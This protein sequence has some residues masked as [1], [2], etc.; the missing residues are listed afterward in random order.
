MGSCSLT[1]VECD[2][3][4]DCVQDTCVGAQPFLHCDHGTQVAGVLGAKGDSGRAIA[5]VSWYTRIMPV[6][7][8]YPGTLSPGFIADL[9]QGI[10]Y[11][12]CHLVD[13]MNISSA[14]FQPDCPPPCSQALRDAIDDARK[15]DI[16]VVV[17]AGNRGDNI[18][19]DPNSW[20]YPCQYTLNNIICV[21]SSDRSDQWGTD[22][23]GAISVDLAAP[24][25]E[26]MTLKALDPN[27]AAPV[28]GSSFAAPHVSGV[29]ALMRALS[30]DIPVKLIRDR[31]LDP[32]SLDLL[33]VF[34]PDP[35]VGTHPVATG[36]RLNAHKCLVDHDSVS[37]D[38][39]S[40]LTASGVVCTN[41]INL[42]WTATADDGSTGDPATFNQVRVSQ[43]SIADP[44]AWLRAAP[45]ASAPVPAAPG[46]MQS[47]V[48]GGL[49]PSTT[50]YFRMRSFDEW[51]NG[52]MSNQVTTTTH[53]LCTASY[54]EE[55]ERRCY[56]TGCGP[57]SCCNYTCFF[58][59]G[60]AA[61]DPCPPEACNCN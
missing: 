27:A 38:A 40:N 50:Y 23:T 53:A 3:N 34:S 4:E 24:G 19:Q 56:S 39:V 57:A 14:V 5:G 37:P 18:D 54:C 43:T 41:S 59:P 42:T 46:T 6:K 2:G 26:I 35:N 1:E 33:D 25:R 13:V 36:G 55:E 28:S 32:N 49:K 58:D 47:M 17:A 10:D 21:T 12:T 9:I 61:P 30:P 52:P 7:I 20:S 15:R 51:G 48:F 45:A 11:A 29:I 60:C 22:N 44:N 16:P 31:L 8:F